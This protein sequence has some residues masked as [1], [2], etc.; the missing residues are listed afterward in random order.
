MG[1]LILDF[2]TKVTNSD[3]ESSRNYNQALIA[4]RK[5]YFEFALSIAKTPK[6]QKE[7]IRLSELSLKEFYIFLRG[8]EIKLATSGGF[9]KQNE[10]AEQYATEIKDWPMLT[11]YFLASRL[12]ESNGRSSQIGYCQMEIDKYLGRAKRQYITPTPYC[13]RDNQNIGNENE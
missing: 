8:R 9:G 11:N 5:A 7:V 6:A 3:W 4:G 10:Q 13:Q 1:S 12:V 2:G